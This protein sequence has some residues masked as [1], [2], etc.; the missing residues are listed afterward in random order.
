MNAKEDTQM[1]IFQYV[2]TWCV[3]MLYCILVCIILGILPSLEVVGTIA[4]I[5][6]IGTIIYRKLSW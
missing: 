1:R 6:G 3:L 2:I 5:S 4:L